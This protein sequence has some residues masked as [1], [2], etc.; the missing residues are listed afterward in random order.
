VQAW[1]ALALE[2]KVAGVIARANNSG[3]RL[4]NTAQ[5]HIKQS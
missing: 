1:T 5:D 2:T 3:G 4:L